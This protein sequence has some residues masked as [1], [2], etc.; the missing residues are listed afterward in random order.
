M[1]GA[2]SGVLPFVEGLAGGVAAIVVVGPLARWAWRRFVR[3]VAADVEELLATTRRID[4]QVTPN[5]GT[6][7]RLADRVV[8]LERHAGVTTDAAEHPGTAR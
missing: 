8:R 3:S 7:D 2:D 4:E 1:L 5:G 6:T